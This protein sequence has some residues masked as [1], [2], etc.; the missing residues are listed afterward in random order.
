[1]LHIALLDDSTLQLDIEQC[2]VK[3]CLDEFAVEAEIKTYTEGLVLYRDVKAGATFDLLIMDI[4]LPD[5]NGIELASHLRDL[6]ETGRILFLSSSRDYAVQ[7]YDVAA[8]Y[9]FLKPLDRGK[10]MNVMK[11]T[12]LKC[13]ELQRDGTV[14]VNGE[15]GL[16]RLRREEILYA[17]VED[18]RPVYMLTD[19]RKIRCKA[20][21]GRFRDAV[22][23]L[24]TDTGFIECGLSCVVRRAAIDTVDENGLILRDG[25]VLYLSNAAAK[26]VMRALRK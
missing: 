17:S 23:P 10:F 21:R 14:T 6:G 9:Y 3:D 22:A 11:D 2:L 12:L 26:D 13:L 25:T 8:T 20:L 1:M 5:V 4:I 18:R 16:V 24:L 15:D 19:G 7:S